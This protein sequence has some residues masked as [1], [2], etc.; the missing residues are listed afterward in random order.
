MALETSMQRSTWIADG[1]HQTSSNH[2]I[3]LSNFPTVTQTPVSSR[4]RNRGEVSGD[5]R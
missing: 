4:R 2:H 1:T 5:S 3:C